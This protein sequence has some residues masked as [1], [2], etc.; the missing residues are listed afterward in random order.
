VFKV[1]SL[2]ILVGI[3][4]MRMNL[5]LVVLFWMGLDIFVFRLLV[6]TFVV[7]RYSSGV[8]LTHD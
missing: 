4:I 7:I 6:S 5:L 8:F 1:C 3:K 2:T